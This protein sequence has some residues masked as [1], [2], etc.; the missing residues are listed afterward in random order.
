MRS[1]I[2]DEDEVDVDANNGNGI[3]VERT[4]RIQGHQAPRVSGEGSE[5]SLVNWKAD[6]YTEER[7]Q[8]D[9]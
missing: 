2:G 5:S 4:V 7:R 6:V 1:A 8:K 3:T 9:I